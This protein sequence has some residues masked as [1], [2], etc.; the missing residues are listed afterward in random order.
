MQTRIK[1]ARY[2]Q[3]LDWG[4]VNQKR[5]FVWGIFLPLS[6][7][8]NQFNANSWVGLQK[9]I[10]QHSVSNR[11]QNTVHPF[12]ADQPSNQVS[13]LDHRAKDKGGPV[14]RITLRFYCSTT[15]TESAPR[16]GLN[17]WWPLSAGIQILSYESVQRGQESWWVRAVG[18]ET[19]WM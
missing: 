15:Q 12:S 6:C 1:V 14:W 3:Q 8:G 4:S 13:E 18:G 2:L 7:W 17:P 11:C 5:G 19:W 9:Y 10:R 16:L